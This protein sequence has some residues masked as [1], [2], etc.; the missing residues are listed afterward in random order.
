MTTM[1][2]GALEKIPS[3]IACSTQPGDGK[4]SPHAVYPP[5]RYGPT[6]GLLL[7]ETSLPG[8]LS[9]VPFSGMGG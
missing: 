4:G 6:R 5:V 3:P 8:S 9:Q 1:T 7:K 2:H